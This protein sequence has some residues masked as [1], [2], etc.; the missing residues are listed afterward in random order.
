M[1][2]HLTVFCDVTCIMII[3]ITIMTDK[4]TN[5][6]N[7]LVKQWTTTTQKKKF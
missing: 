5:R 2:L 3:I 6:Y 1:Y 7:Q 4:I